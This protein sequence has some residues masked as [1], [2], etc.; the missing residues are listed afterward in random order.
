MGM[1][2]NG[3][4]PSS[5]TGEYFR[6]N[7]WW[8]HPLWSY[9]EI[10][11]PELTAKVEHGHTNDGDGLNAEDSKT[12][13]AILEQELKHGRTQEYESAHTA[14]L[15]ALPDEECW[16]CKG[17]GTR[18]DMVVDHGCNG[19]KGKGKVRPHSTHYPFSVEN[20]QEFAAFL[21]DCGGFEIY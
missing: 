20:V 16:L 7:V 8:W 1:D 9:C 21:K 13:A 11:A 17:T 4:N 19:C 10:V 6:N 3:K 14:K 5:K 12:L 2:V 18:G 15:N